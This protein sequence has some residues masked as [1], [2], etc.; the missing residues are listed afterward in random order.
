[1]TLSRS[2]K[3]PVWVG[4]F[5]K[6]VWDCMTPLAFIG[7]IGFSYLE[8]EHLENHSNS[9]VVGVYVIPHELVGGDKDGAKAIAGFRLDTLKL[10][11][12]F[13]GWPS[14]C[15][16]VNNRRHN[17]RGPYYSFNGNYDNGSETVSMALRVFSEASSDAQ[18]RL[19]LN[20]KTN[21][22]TFIKPKV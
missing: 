19:Q 15:E 14:A 10:Q 9:W 6:K 17:L 8:P 21:K 2:E 20:P 18:P 11:A 16:W 5:V 1:M 22:V 13:S 12:V 4:E 7:E 3:G